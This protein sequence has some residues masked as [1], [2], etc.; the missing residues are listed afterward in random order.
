M[1]RISISGTDVMFEFNEQTD[2]VSF[3]DL[4]LE[5]GF[6]RDQHGDSTIELTVTEV[7]DD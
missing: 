7:E 6:I 4:V 1:Y 2:A 5:C 3:I